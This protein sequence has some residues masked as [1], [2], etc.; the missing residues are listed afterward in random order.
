MAYLAIGDKIVIPAIETRAGGPINLQAKTASA[1]TTAQNITPDSG[2]DGLSKVTIN[3]ATKQNKTVAPSTSQQTVSPDSGY[4]GLNAVTVSAVTK[5][6]DS[7]IAAGN[8]KSGVTILGV[9]G[10]YSGGSITLQEKTVTPTV[11][12]QSV[13]PDTGYGGLSKVTVNAA[14]KQNKT[15]T[16]TAAQQTVSAD[17][18]YYGLGTVTVNATPLETKTVTPTAAQQTVSPSSGKIGLSSVTVNAAPLETKN[19]TPTTS[20]QTINPSSGKIGMSSVTV[21]AVTNTIDSNIVA[22]NIKKDVTILGVK[23]TFEGGGGGDTY[24]IVPDTITWAHNTYV[25]ISLDID[26]QG[27]LEVTKS[28]G[29]GTANNMVICY[30]QSDTYSAADEITQID[31]PQAAGTYEMPITVWWD[32]Q[33]GAHNDHNNHTITYTVVKGGGSDIKLQQ[34]TATPTTSQQNIT[35]DTG[36]D[37]LSKVTI[38]AVTSTI[39]SNIKATNIKDGVTI[40]GVEGTYE[41]SGGLQSATSSATVSTKN[42]QI[43]FSNLKGAPKEYAVISTNS[44]KPGKNVI[45]L[46]CSLSGS[47]KRMT[48]WSGSNCYA[49]SNFTS[50]TGSNNLTIKTSGTSTNGGYFSSSYQ[51][52]YLYE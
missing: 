31:I 5:T 52:N 19:I 23:G 46:G 2:Y 16:P 6:I 48:S 38:N 11:N 32:N 8:I 21:S 43:T 34:K 41:G 36:Y 13:T 9:T 42:Q 18:G 33:S 1:A 10:N 12:Q 22:G 39:D 15:V 14:T 26:A 17:S 3:A 49:I 24:S 37:G 28:A 35:A 4:Y 7:N 25:T 20:Q 51:L 27:N 29:S 47:S 50:T 45:V 44:L 40:L 30:P